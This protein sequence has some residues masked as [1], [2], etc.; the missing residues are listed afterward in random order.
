MAMVYDKPGKGNE[1]VI[2]IGKDTV[3]YAHA[4]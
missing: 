4:D 1:L 2:E 3:T